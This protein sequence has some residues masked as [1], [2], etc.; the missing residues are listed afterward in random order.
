MVSFPVRIVSSP[1]MRRNNS[2]KTS[3]ISDVALDGLNLHGSDRPHKTKRR[4]HIGDVRASH[5]FYGFLLKR[6]QTKAGPGDER[7]R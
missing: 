7:G 4:G 1:V 5:A 2:R 6:A 3:I